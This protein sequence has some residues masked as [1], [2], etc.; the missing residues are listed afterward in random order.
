MPVNR[1]RGKD[2]AKREAEIIPRNAPRKTKRTLHG[3][4][5][6]RHNAWRCL[7]IS[8]QGVLS[9]VGLAWR[10]A[11]HLSVAFAFL[12]AIAFVPPDREHVL[13][14]VVGV[15]LGWC[16]YDA[17]DGGR[18]CCCCTSGYKMRGHLVANLQ[19]RSSWL[20]LGLWKG[21]SFM[22]SLPNPTYESA[23]QNLCLLV[24]KWARLHKRD[25]LLDVGCGCGDSIALWRR[26][27]HVFHIT[28]IDISRDEVNFAQTHMTRYV[29]M[30][31]GCA[32]S[33][34]AVIK[35]SGTASFENFDATG[36]GNNG[37]TD[38]LGNNVNVSSTTSGGG[39]V[40]TT[41]NRGRLSPRTSREFSRQ[42]HN[43]APVSE[44]EMEELERTSR[45]SFSEE[46]SGRID[47]DSNN[48]TLTGPSAASG[49][50][51]ENLSRD[52]EKFS[53]DS[54]I[55]SLSLG[56]NHSV[57][58][59]S[60]NSSNC[61]SSGVSSSSNIAMSATATTSA[62]EGI[63]VCIGDATKLDLDDAS[64]SKV[65]C[66]DSAYYFSSRKKF[67][68]EAFRV[69]A[70]GGRLCI[71]DICLQ[72]Y[73][74]TC[75]GKLVLF[76][77]C[78]FTGVPRANMCECEEYTL[79]LTRTG[80]VNVQCRETLDSEVFLGY[81]NFISKQKFKLK[82]AVQP[83]LFSRHSAAASFFSFVARMRWLYFIVVTADKPEEGSSLSNPSY[84]VSPPS[85]QRTMR[86][87]S[88][89]YQH[90]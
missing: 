67:F 62:I 11:F 28:G 63:D 17:M 65:V 16:A 43:S 81:S 7:S 36:S 66:I 75:I 15:V 2:G 85:M 21:G 78:I 49:P 27:Y 8:G 84:R 56:S 6:V 14:S 29:N 80:F 23:C 38:V 83:S 30:Y 64:F 69:L 33:L 68:A 24:G 40:G 25:R 31:Y 12:L 61:V 82:D 51:R 1:R 76:L 44:D 77:L 52:S 79:S 71:G 37:V 48:L 88:S 26:V 60:S 22:S 5:K 86:S 59:D 34:L 57:S 55:R 74:T 35:R 39:A 9:F 53:R 72:S 20:N 3:R 45:T 50:L 18:V 10:F 54:R 41:T 73:P 42:Q 19:V 90:A 70:P 89:L 4:R 46:T 47:F 32:P 87:A 13:W 58:S